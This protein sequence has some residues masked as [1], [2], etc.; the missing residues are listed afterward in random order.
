MG[1]TQAE[2][3]TIMVETPGGHGTLRHLA[4]VLALS[5]TRPHWDKPSPVLGSSRPEWLS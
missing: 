4:P 3:D 5:E 1:L 2:L